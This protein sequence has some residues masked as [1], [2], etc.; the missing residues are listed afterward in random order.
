[1]A[2]ES[3][4]SAALMNRRHVEVRQRRLR[5]PDADT[6]SSASR[7]CLV[8]KSAVEWTATVLNAEFPAGAQDAKRNLAAVAMT[9]FSIILNYSMMN[10]RLAEFDGFAVLGQYR[11]HTAALS[12]SI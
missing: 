10:K 8:L 12:D 2:T 4:T 6:V 3:V 9:T 1:M 7:T 5:R 11:G